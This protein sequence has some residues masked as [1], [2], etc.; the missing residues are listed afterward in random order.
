MPQNLTRRTFFELG[1]ATLITAT[2]PGP[3]IAAPITYRLNPGR[4]RVGF[5]V[6]LGND[7]LTGE[8]PVRSADLALDFNQIGN[9]R[10]SVVLNAANTRMGV[11]FATEAV[12]APDLLD[13]ARHPTIAFQS[14]RVRQGPS[15]AEAIVDGNVT[16]KGVTR[17]VTLT[18][19][20]TQD[21]A[22]LG[23]SNPE[24]TLILK[25]TVNREDFGMT[26]YRGLVGPRVSLDI[27]AR[28]QRA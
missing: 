19:V 2:L 8:M 12:L 5:G 7:A 1:A 11:F 16:I 17:P 13:V 9:S 6:E 27:R 18:T 25:G 15:E 28:I 4:S 24:L 22:T 20:L 10:V 14:T 26:A 3:A 23:Q 21:R